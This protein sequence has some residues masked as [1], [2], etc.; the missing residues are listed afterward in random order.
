MSPSERA[1]KEQEARDA[2]IA[3]AQART[4]AANARYETAKK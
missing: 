4:E 1:A 3:A 2:R